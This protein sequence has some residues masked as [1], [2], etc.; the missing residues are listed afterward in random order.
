MQRTKY[1][2]QTRPTDTQLNW[3]ET[4]RVQ[5]IDQRL[6]S[7]AQMGV[8]WGFAVTVNSVD[9]TKI[10]ISRGEGYSG[11]LYQINEF[12]T[13]GSAQRISTYT[14]TPSG[15]DDTGPAA[16]KQGLAD[17]TAGALNY[18][19]LVYGE[20]EAQPLGERSYPFTTRQ[21][22][23]TETFTVSVLTAV[24]W[25]ALSSVALN[26]MILVAIVTASGAG[27]ALSS[28]NIDQFVQPKTL[29]SAS[30]PQ[31]IFGTTIVGIADVTPLGTGTLRWDPAVSQ[32]FWTAP[33]GTEGTGLSISDSGV[34][35]LYSMNLNYTINVNVVWG[36]LSL[37]AADTSENITVQSLYGRA[38]PMFSGVDQIH[39]D[40]VGSGQ[41]SSTNP[42][43]LTLADIGGGT[44]DHADLFHVNGISK[45]ADATQL[46]CQIDLVNDRI[47][48]TSLGGYTN[49]FLVDGVTL[50]AVVGS[51][52]SNFDTV[53]IPVSGQYLV[54][55]DS[56]GAIS[57]VQIGDYDDLTS[58]E[59]ANFANLDIW[60]MHNNVAGTGE[61]EWDNATEAI[62]YKAQG[63]LAFGDWVYVA[64]DP[65]VAGNYGTYKVY[66]SDTDN[67]IILQFSGVI[68]ASNTETFTVVKDETTYADESTLKLC[69]VSWDATNEILTNLRDIRRFVTAD[70]RAEFEE[71]HDEDGY[72]TKTLRNTLSIYNNASDVGLDVVADN[73]GIRA[74][75]L[76]DTALAAYAVGDV[77]IYGSAAAATGA[78]I[79]AGAD[80][81][82]YI[83][84]AVNTGVFAQAAGDTGVLG[85]A[86]GDIGV[87]G[88]VGGGTAVYGSAG[89]EVGV[90]GYAVA[91][92][93]AY[94]KAA[95]NLGVYGSAGG[96]TGVFGRAIA[97]TGVYGSAGG[98]TGV[99]GKAVANTGVYGSAGAN[100]GVYGYAL[101]NTGV[102]GSVGA[103]TGVAGEAVANTGVY[104]SAG[105]DGG[106]YGYAV[107]NTGVF[108]SAGAA[109]GVAGSAVANTGVYGY[110]GANVGMYAHA[111]VDTGLY[112]TAGGN[113]GVR[114]AAAG[115]T[116]LLA[117]AI[118]NTGVYGGAAHYGGYF[119][120]GSNWAV[121]NVIGLYGSAI[122]GV[123]AESAIGI[124]GYA[125]GVEA[126]AILGSAAGG[127]GSGVFGSAAGASGIGVYGL[128]A[129]AVGRGVFGRADVSAGIGVQGIASHADALAGGY[130][131]AL[132]NASV[133][134]ILGGAISYA[135]VAGA[136]EGGEVG[137]IK[138][139][140]GANTYGIKYYNP[141]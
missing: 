65:V 105:A 27:T 138:L 37:V 34:Y 116:G 135:G 57:R 1:W 56:A 60:D 111:V 78:F 123:D 87:F 103:A 96:A 68:G 15:T 104:G 106:V 107:A 110:A 43:A 94:G 25:A 52:Y 124:K 122:N 45:D 134:L 21:T 39:R 10:D 29:P 50:T 6:R 115:D 95:V 72:H 30:Q 31:T 99:F 97:D 85:S 73:Y 71:E 117:S 44:L 40:M 16:I 19:A 23:V 112:A 49:S 42:H 83:T 32:M 86:G 51:I 53:P 82:A 66:S 131:A 75:A 141:A 137:A 4:S 128:G 28:A 100:R 108:G 20:V 102:Y 91:N 98:A 79:Y 101:V 127:T 61:I 140:I 33:G 64:N 55:V 125:V 70:N 81:G 5:S 9:N 18:V 93:G 109:T 22:I 11:G 114:V 121:N 84:A 7:S 36:S 80:T 62:R 113:I 3:T 74:G 133:A 59:F 77:G 69:V 119:A 126:T 90:Y 14:E 17:Y 63:D 47:Q 76:T 129:G 46:E 13:A 89:G 35:V 48:V 38:I 26:N 8:K 118:G 139:M 130:F 88:K 132:N 67:W 120:A 136:A 41:P 12:E 2:N 24:Q 92:T 54:Y 58:Q